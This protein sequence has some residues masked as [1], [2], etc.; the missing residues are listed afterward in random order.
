MGEPSM[1]NTG[2]L[3]RNPFP[4]IRPFTGAEDKFFFGREDSVRETMNLLLEHRFVAL[5]GASGSGKTSLIQSGVIP[6]LLTHEKQEWIPV[7][8]RPGIKPLESLIRGF[9]QVFPK[10]LLEDDVQTYLTGS[11]GLGDLIIDKGLGSHNYFLVVDQ[12]EELFRTGPSGKR[13]GKNPDATR[14][15]EQLVH[16]VKK[17]RP[18]IHVMFSIQSDFIDA[19]SS[20]RS[21]TDLMN[22]SKYLVPQMTVEALTKA[23]LG[24]IQQTG[25]SVEEGFVE[26][27][28]EDLEEVDTQL[29]QLQHA[30]MR[31]WDHWASEGNKDQPISI[32]NYQAVGTVKTA[33]GD[34]LEEAFAELDENQQAICEQLFKSITSKS[35]QYNGF[36][37]QATLG[38]VARIIQCSLDD[39]IDVAE[40]FRKPGRSF[41]SPHT[42]ITLASDSY[43]E[44]SHESLI[45]I[46][47]RLRDWVDE[48]AESRKMYQKL[49]EA[50]A[51]YQQGRTELWRPPE[52]QIALH[53]RDTEKPTPAWGVQYN[54]AYERAM[55]FLST[56]EEEYLWEEERKVIKHRRR[57]ILNRSITIFMVVLVGVLGIVFF[58]TRNRPPGVEEA[59]QPMDQDLTYEY[60]NQPSV[61]AVTGETES[62]PSTESLQDPDP[63][64]VEEE[65]VVRADSRNTT[66]ATTTASDR[67][68]SQN[69]RTTTTSQQGTSGSGQ[70]TTARSQTGNSE[71]AQM[72]VQRA[73]LSVARNV[74]LQSIDISRNPDLQGLLAYQAY[75][76]NS[77]Y[78]GRYYDSDIYTGLYAALKKLISPAYNIY[79]NLRT[80]VKGIEWLNRTGSILTAS[81]DGSIKILSGN[82]ADR[83]SQIELIN[84]GLNNECLAISPN[85]RVAAV[86]TN[87]GGLIFIELENRGAVIH[88]NTDQ[89][90]IVLFLANLGNSGSFISAGTGNSILK[91]NYSSF[92]VSELL[93]TSA[94]PSAL[95]S[96]A[97][98]TKVTFGTRDGKLFEMNVNDPGSVRELADYGRNHV[99]AVTYSPGGQYLVVGLLDGSLRVLAGEGR[100]SIATLRG[101]GARVSDLDYSPD[102]RYLVAGSH[103]GNVYLWHSADWNNPPIVF[104]EN[105]GFVLSVCFSRNS[106]Y[107]YSGS[108]NYPRLIGRPSGSAGMAA[109]FC[110]LVGRNLTQAEW[111]QYIG[112]DIPYE[113]TCP[114]AN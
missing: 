31:T 15:V 97:D 2:V 14:F 89:G 42:G 33:L 49:S 24:P 81:S 3:K 75:Q 67:T 11:Q 84:T 41:L 108:V 109:D 44:L 73:M 10:K 107:F 13:N 59:D 62:D 37:R 52:L 86:G 93:A 50:S 57:L 54:P 56:S 80:S 43:I 26:S 87:G 99:R 55:V 76:I 63:E 23:I 104:T 22:K 69:D 71:A 45:R 110:T 28:L 112:G 46:W 6:A 21:L 66:P 82:I 103:D 102:G 105:N 29:P 65:P 16:A 72:E 88:Q 77:R 113:E 8:I 106:G 35:E 18:A 114:G 100:S 70:Q 4:G 111:E 58:G 98:G 39:L 5:V 34:H 68:T 90:K 53:W 74:A 7:T 9:Q 51:L 92:G 78:S 20:F 32:D 85:E 27:L 12:F 91:W 83:A 79:P 25:A 36:R 95:A 101:P 40:V 61:P 47:E 60:R 64:T 19:C 96:S 30:L 48:E 17:E 94:R 38:N 1:I